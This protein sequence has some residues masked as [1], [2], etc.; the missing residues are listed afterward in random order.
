[1]VHCQLVQGCMDDQSSHPSLNYLVSA[2]VEYQLLNN[3]KMEKR[4]QVM[5]TELL[6]LK[7]YLLGFLPR[8][9]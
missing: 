6:S 1:M 4:L 2:Q 5:Q 3:P 9:F 7:E 8:N